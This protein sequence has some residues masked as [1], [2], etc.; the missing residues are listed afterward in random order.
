MPESQLSVV[1]QDE[2]HEVLGDRERRGGGRRRGVPCDHAAAERDMEVVYETTAVAST[3]A[4]NAVDDSPPMD[5]EQPCPL[6]LAPGSTCSSRRATATPGIPPPTTPM[7]RD[8]TPP[9]V[10]C[11]T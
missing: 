9:P 3:D 6:R 11:A 1:G 10:T 4:W 8:A 2:F 7:P 5:L